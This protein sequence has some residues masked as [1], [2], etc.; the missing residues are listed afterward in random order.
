[1]NKDLLQAIT[2]EGATPGSDDQFRGSLERFVW[3]GGLVLRGLALG[4]GDPLTKA[5]TKLFDGLTIPQPPAP[6]PNPQ[7]VKKRKE[8]LAEL[9][10][11]FGFSKPF[12]KNVRLDDIAGN[13]DLIKAILLI[14]TNSLYFDPYTG[15]GCKKR[16]RQV[17]KL[18]RKA[19]PKVKPPKPAPKAGKGKANA[20]KPKGKRKK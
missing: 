3:P 15:T 17:V 12:Q 19:E 8:A 11:I 10:K 1:L 18:A 7:V 6:N 9:L 2:I 5:Y 4:A 20:G 16:M 13:D 14:K